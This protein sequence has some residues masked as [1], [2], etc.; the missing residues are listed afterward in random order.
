MCFKNVKASFFGG[1]GE[2]EGEEWVA[3]GGEGGQDRQSAHFL[4]TL[5]GQ[6]ATEPTSQIHKPVSPQ[7]QFG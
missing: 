6:Q 4:A 2:G 3:E 1:L 7:G 5:F